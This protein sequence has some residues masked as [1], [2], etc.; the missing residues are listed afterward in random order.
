[1]NIIK[2]VYILMP[3]SIIMTL[4]W[5]PPAAI[6]GDTSRIIYYH[7][8]LAWISVLAFII[9]GIYSGVYLLTIKNRYHRIYLGESKLGELLELGP[10]RNI[11]NGASIDLYLLHKP[12]FNFIK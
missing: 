6:L 10:A 1:M 11:D 5:A 7:V 12:A 9:S 3:G 4:L 8:P 2:F